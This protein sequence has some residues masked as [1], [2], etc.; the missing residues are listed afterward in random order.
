MSAN[1]ASPAV[2][3]AILNSLFVMATTLRA[4]TGP[5]VNISPITGDNRAAR[6]PRDMAIAPYRADCSRIGP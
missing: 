5:A 6:K 2:I 3:S 1:E 4:C